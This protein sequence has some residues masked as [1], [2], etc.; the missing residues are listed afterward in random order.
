MFDFKIRD[1]LLKPMHQQQRINDALRVVDAE[2]QSFLT[3]IYYARKSD[4]SFKE[5]KTQ[6][7]QED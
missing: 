1:G 6:S 7:S 2:Q 3:L 5:E 4:A